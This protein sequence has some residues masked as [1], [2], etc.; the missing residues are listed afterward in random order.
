MFE[1]VVTGQALEVI[2][3]LKILLEPFYLGVGTGLALQLG[4]RISYDLDFFTPE[5]F[6][7]EIIL[8]DLKPHKIHS[9][10]KQGI[11]CEFK[12]VR[13]SFL[14]YDLP[15]IFKPVT[16]RNI[17]VAHWL[18]IAAEKF[19][20]VSQ[21]GSKKD[22]YDIYFSIKNSSIEEVCKAFVER[23]KNTG[24]NKY[25]VLKSLVYFEDAEDEPDPFLLK[26]KLN[27]S[28]LKEF[29][30]NNIKEFERFIL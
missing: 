5:V 27:W 24:I 13:L 29:F 15:L 1:E 6:I 17:K 11:Y 22:F 30:K 18:D 4:H 26:E 9:I 19:K 21:R 2:E 12:G 16:W 8:N 14:Y 23:F 25:H 10:E 7:P 3:D 28:E 20:T